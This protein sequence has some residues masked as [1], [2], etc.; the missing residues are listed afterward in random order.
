M[1]LTAAEAD[2]ME[3]P[4]TDLQVI[5]GTHRHRRSLP[6]LGIRRPDTDDYALRSDCAHLVENSQTGQMVCDSYEDPL[7]PKVCE[8]FMPGS[9]GCRQLRARAGVDTMADFAVYLATT[10][11]GE[12][13]GRRELA[14]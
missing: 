13:V 10:D 3:A 1:S 11:G 14:A 6:L 12:L 7:R 9:Y 5:P 8:E 2:F 4:G